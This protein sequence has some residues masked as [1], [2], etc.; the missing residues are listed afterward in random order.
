M[1]ISANFYFIKKPNFKLRWSA[2]RTKSTWSLFGKP[3]YYGWHNFT[4]FARIF[5]NRTEA[6]C[7]WVESPWPVG[8]FRSRHGKRLHQFSYVG[9][10][11]NW[12]SDNCRKWHSTRESSSSTRTATAVKCAHSRQ[13]AP[14]KSSTQFTNFWSKFLIMPEKCIMRRSSSYSRCT[15]HQ[16]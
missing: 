1:L 11:F 15:P 5:H 4:V 10:H 6:N 8:Y 2:W 14:I 16:R 12:R 7:K 9:V 13:V 3:C